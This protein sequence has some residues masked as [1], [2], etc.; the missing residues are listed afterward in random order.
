MQFS[1][2][3]RLKQRD[4][5]VQHINL[6]VPVAGGDGGN[7][8]AVAIPAVEADAQNDPYQQGQSFV[9]CARAILIDWRILHQRS[10]SVCQ[11]RTRALTS[12]AALSPFPRHRSCTLATKTGVLAGNSKR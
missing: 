9:F 3:R 4:I 12:A 8:S 10:T 6:P 11:G 5:A 1:D 7:C 2:D